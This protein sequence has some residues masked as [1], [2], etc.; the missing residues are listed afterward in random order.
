MVEQPIAEDHL[1][2][3]LISRPNHDIEKIME[4]EF[5][6]PRQSLSYLEKL[7]NLNKGKEDEHARLNCNNNHT[8]CSNNSNGNQYTNNGNMQGS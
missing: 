8:E 3:V 1:I 2:R 7:D 5:T 4:R 6:E